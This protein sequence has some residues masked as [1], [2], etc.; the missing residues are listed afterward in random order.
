MDNH[1]LHLDPPGSTW[2]PYDLALSFSPVE[3]TLICHIPV[4]RSPPAPRGVYFQSS[5]PSSPDKMEVQQFV[6]KTISAFVKQLRP[7]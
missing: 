6:F 7:V 3:L 4:Y 5:W 2:I 1:T